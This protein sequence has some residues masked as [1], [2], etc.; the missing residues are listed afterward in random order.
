LFAAVGLAAMTLVARAPTAV[1]PYLL[2]QFAAVSGMLAFSFSVWQLW[3]QGAIGLGALA[4]LVAL[5]STL[6]SAEHPGSD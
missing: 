5:L 3:F 6:Q 4:I 1:Q 2:A